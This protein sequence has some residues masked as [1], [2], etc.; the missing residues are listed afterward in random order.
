MMSTIRIKED[1]IKEYLAKKIAEYWNGKLIFVPVASGWQ[2]SDFYINPDT[3]KRERVPGTFDKITDITGEISASAQGE[4][5]VFYI[6]YSVNI[7]TVG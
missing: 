3:G 5:I 6:T 7:A 1:K 4:E 2:W